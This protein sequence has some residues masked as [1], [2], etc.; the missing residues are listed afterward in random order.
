MTFPDKV[1]Q[2]RKESGLTQVALAKGIGVSDRT[3]KRYEAGTVEPTLSALL[4]LADFFQ[5]SLD[6]LVGRS[7]TRER[8]P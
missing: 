5:I 7:E 3:I 1:R 2:I 6:Y 8:L 4:T